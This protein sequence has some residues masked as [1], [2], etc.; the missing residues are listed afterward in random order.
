MWKNRKQDKDVV[1]VKR[2]AQGTNQSI[3]EVVE[4]NTT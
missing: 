4:I 2:G 3:S 1:V